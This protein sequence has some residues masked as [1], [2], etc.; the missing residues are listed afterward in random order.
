[1]AASTAMLGRGQ[2]AAVYT[3]RSG[4]KGSGRRLEA[5]VAQEWGVDMAR[6]MPRVAGEDYGVSSIPSH[7]PVVH[8]PEDVGLSARAMQ[9][10]PRQVE[11]PRQVQRAPAGAALASRIGIGQPHPP[12]DPH[13]GRKAPQREQSISE[14]VDSVA[15]KIDVAGLTMDIMMPIYSELER[16][17]MEAE[18]R[19]EEAAD[20]IAAL[21]KKKDKL[22]SRVA[23]E[24]EARTKNDAKVWRLSQDLIKAQTAAEHA[25]A[26]LNAANDQLEAKE[27]VLTD[28]EQRLLRERSDHRRTQHNL[29]KARRDLAAANAKIEAKEKEVRPLQLQNLEMAQRLEEAQESVAKIE[30]SFSALT[31]K[32]QDLTERFAEQSGALQRETEAREDAQECEAQIRILL[33]DEADKKGATREQLRQAKAQIQ[34]LESDL[35]RSKLAEGLARSEHNQVLDDLELERTAH[36]GSRKH[37]EHTFGTLKTMQTVEGALR[38]ELAAARDTIDELS[39]EKET[40]LNTMGVVQQK[41]DVVIS[42]LNRGQRVEK[43]A[44]QIDGSFGGDVAPSSLSQPAP[45]SPRASAESPRMP[46]LSPRGNTKVR[47]F[48]HSANLVEVERTGLLKELA[49]VMSLLTPTQAERLTDEQTQTIVRPAL[50]VEISSL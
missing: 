49:V 4:R 19:A 37:L 25:E 48:K 3:P 14:F 23:A 35:K 36:G 38:A 6:V 44:S 11:Q 46:V 45:G 47:V 33:E 5:R 9:A 43:Q 30:S 10:P 50:P 40:L 34:Q 28:Q 27:R 22:M 26:S 7:P 29:D 15:P 16:K 39:G 31:S 8:A 18:R 42:W 12:V 21:N 13:P 2:P 41:L 24:T 32:H 1:M 17:A 20:T